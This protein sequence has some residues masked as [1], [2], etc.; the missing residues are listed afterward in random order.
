MFRATVIQADGELIPFIALARIERVGQPAG[1][2]L[3]GVRVYTSRGLEEAQ[4]SAGLWIRDRGA[5]ASQLRP[6]V[7]YGSRRR[8][9]RSGDGQ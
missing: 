6:G 1:S 7:A 8:Q 5:G 3:K 2:P 4:V 9:R